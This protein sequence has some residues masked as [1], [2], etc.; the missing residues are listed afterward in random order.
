[1]ILLLSGPALATLAF[2]ASNLKSFQ[3]WKKEKVQ[4]TLVQSNLIRSR[5]LEAQLNKNAKLQESLERQLNQVRWNSEVAKEL[6]V[7]DYFILY[8]SQQNQEDRFKIAAQKMTLDEVADLI[9]AYT[10]MLSYKRHELVTNKKDVNTSEKATFIPS[11][12]AQQK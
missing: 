3:E 4:A 7:T 10:G 1:M 11:Q 2:T 8:L 12:A 6:T 5:I 9:E